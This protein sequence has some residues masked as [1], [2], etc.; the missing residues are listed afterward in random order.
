MRTIITGA[1]SGMGRAIAHRFAADAAEQETQLLLVDLSADRLET[2][3]H[4][5]ARTGARIVTFV[6]DLADPEAC[7]QIGSMAQSNLGGLDTLVSNAG[8]VAASTGLLD[9]TIDKYELD[10][11]VNARA[12]WLLAKSAHS[13]LKQSR[14]AL[15][16]TASLASKQV[17]PFLGAYSASKAALVMLVRQMA[18][19]WGKDGIRCNCVSPG[20]VLTAMNQQVVKQDPSTAEA[21][22]ALGRAGHSEE[23]ADVVAFLAGPHSS[24]VT[25]ANIVVDGGMEVSLM[26]SLRKEA[27]VAAG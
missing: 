23:I 14:G 8:V 19:E 15:V 5:L 7:A 27:P 1:A 18:F 3:A 6:G 17:A 2:V 20:R 25:G 4:E 10:M 16:A 21:N 22:L 13:M 26:A 24:Y 12:T 9:L 11:A